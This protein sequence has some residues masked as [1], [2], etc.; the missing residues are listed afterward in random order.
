MKQMMSVIWFSLITLC[1]VAC[2][3]GNK[4][5]SEPIASLESDW[6]MPLS[7]EQIEELN[8]Y[9]KALTV[10]HFGNY[11]E[12]DDCSLQLLNFSSQLI[13]LDYPAMV[14]PMWRDEEAYVSFDKKMIMALIEQYF[15]EEIQI[16]GIYSDLG[17]YIVRPDMT[18][19]SESVYPELYQCQL[20]EDGTYTIDF[21]LYEF[22]EEGMEHIRLS[23]NW[24]QSVNCKQVGVASATIQHDGNESYILS[25]HPIYFDE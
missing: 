25:Y 14:E 3:S 19:K 11:E 2:S 10:T 22:D 6:V 5:F 15:N 4:K 18:L 12:G 13:Q 21:N 20:N 17:D 7:S 9:F 1:L 24:S 16:T 8:E 23:K